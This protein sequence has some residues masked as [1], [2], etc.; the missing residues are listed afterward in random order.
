VDCCNVVFD[1]YHG[2]IKNIVLGVFQSKDGGR[3]A[4]KSKKKSSCGDNDILHVL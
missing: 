3:V 4:F 1:F 2:G